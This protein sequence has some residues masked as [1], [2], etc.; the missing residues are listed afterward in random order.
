MGGRIIEHPWA[1]VASDLMEFPQSKGQFKYVVMFQDLFTRWVQLRPL[2]SATDKNVAK[3]FEE[4]VLF[5]WGTPDYLLTDNGKEFDN[6]DLGR[7]LEVYG[8][9]RVTT[10][11]Y[12]PQANPVERSN[13]TL[14]TMI[15]T[16]V[17]TDHRNWDKHLHELRH[18][19][20]TAVQSSTKVSPAFLNYGRDRPPVKSLR[21]E[22][23]V[24]GPKIRLLP[25]VWADRVKRLDALR[26]LVTKNLERTH[27]RQAAY[28]NRGRQDV[29]FQVGDFV[30]RKV[31]VLSSGARNFSAKLAPDWEGPYKVIEIKP[32]N[33]YIL[34]MEGGRRNPKVHVKELR[35][36]REGR[37]IEG[38]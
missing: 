26:D 15:A 21:R 36:Y 5:R 16:F 30:M 33:V 7:I 1:V 10:P 29:R 18:A 35:K 13:R 8:V 4:L 9:T 25:E 37:V 14:K 28:Y 3:A 38:K 17:K 11:P 32:P 31:H 22:V 12:H 23:E 2:R 34:D 6:Q 19:I 24:K 27:E 20:N